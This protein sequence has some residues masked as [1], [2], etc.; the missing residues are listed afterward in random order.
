MAQ[1][2]K[3]VD[4]NGATFI[5]E[6]ENVGIKIEGF[7]RRLDDETLEINHNGTDKQIIDLL[8]NHDGSDLPDVKK[9]ALS[10]LIDLGLTEE[11]IAA[12]QADG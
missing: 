12:L 4:F 1:Y 9:S 3:G 6:C 11:E 2:K 5:K 8:K 7:I 10:K